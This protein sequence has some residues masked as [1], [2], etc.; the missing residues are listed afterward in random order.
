MVAHALFNGWALWQ[1]VTGADIESGNLPFYLRDVWY[2]VAALV[3]LPFL[4]RK[5][6]EGGSEAQPLPETAPAEPLTD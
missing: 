4:V 6:S 5:I 3:L 1:L 2:V